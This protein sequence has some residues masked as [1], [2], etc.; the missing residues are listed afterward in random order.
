MTRRWPTRSRLTALLAVL[1]VPLSACGDLSAMNFR[2]DHRLTFTAPQNRASVTFPM[3]VTWTMDDLG[4]GGGETFGIFVDRTP[5]RPGESVE[6]IADGD[7]QCAL[8]AACPD[9]DYLARRGVHVR[10]SSSFV[11]DGLP[12]ITS[13]KPDDLHTIVIVILDAQGRRVGESGWRREFRVE[14]AT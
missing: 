2:N 9:E 1:V 5:M 6:S 12:Q 3:D 10:A 14:D 11:V 13:I 4:L 8:D 7:R